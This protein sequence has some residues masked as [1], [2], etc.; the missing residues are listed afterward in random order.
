MTNILKLPDLASSFAKMKIILDLKRNTTG[1]DI[2]SDAIR[3]SISNKRDPNEIIS[4]IKSQATDNPKVMAEVIG[5]ELTET[6]LNF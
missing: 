3:L 6:I 5:K 1:N 4:W 2:L